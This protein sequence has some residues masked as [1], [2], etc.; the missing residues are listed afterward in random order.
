MN[1][2]FP[3]SRCIGRRRRSAGREADGVLLISFLVAPTGEENTDAKAGSAEEA[4]AFPK[5]TDERVL[6]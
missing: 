4:A 1:P 5:H 3:Q 6:C 2:Y